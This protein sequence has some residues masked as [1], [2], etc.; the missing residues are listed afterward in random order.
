MDK[1]NN[2]LDMIAGIFIVYMIVLH[3]LQWCNLTYVF[4]NVVFHVFSFFMFWFFFKS[5][6]F[7]REKLSK[8]III[9]GCKRLIVP[10]VIFSIVGHLLLCI[11]LLQE[12]DYNWMHYVLSPIKSILLNGSLAGNL[13]LWFLLTLLAVQLIFNYL[14]KKVNI[15]FVVFVGYSIA[16]IL[17]MVAIPLPLY[18]ANI[19]LGIATYGFG[20]KMKNV[21]YKNNVFYFGF[22][23][24][25]VILSLCYSSI[26]FR[27][28][29]VAK[30]FYLTAC[31]YAI[32]ECVIINY[33]FSL[34][35]VRLKKLEYIGRHS[36]NYYVMHWPILLLCSIIV[37]KSISG[38]NLFIIMGVSCMCIMPIIEL[39]V[40]SF[41][42]EW[43]FGEKYKKK[44]ISVQ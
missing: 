20:Y 23:V 36:M 4:G 34:T 12:G 18:F 35:K 25:I 2:S 41:H 44:N 16:C 27:V 30:G 9:G 32:S 39:L 29:Q 14:S 6:M 33:L 8:D 40:Y 28:N 7:Y 17:N 42:G 43:I 21:L 11:K 26:D 1:R 37:G 3:I 22:V 13:P 15:W 31:L 10:F 19:A 38:W 5:G 24:Y